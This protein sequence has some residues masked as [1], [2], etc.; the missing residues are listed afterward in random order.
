MSYDQLVTFLDSAFRS[1][2]WPQVA[3][4]GIVLSPIAMAIILGVIWWEVWV[5]YVR[6]KQFLGLKYTILDLKLPKDTFKSPLAMETVLHSIHNTSDGSMYA[7]FWKGETRP[8]YS[9]EVIS[10]EGNVK[11]LIWT[12]DRRKNNLMSALY[13]QYPGIE[14]TEMPTD[15]AADLQ[16][17]EKT[18]K[19]HC[20]EFKC[21]KPDPYPIKTYVDYGLDKDPKEEFKIDPLTHMIEWLGSLRPNE[22][23]WFQFVVRAH[24]DDQ[25]DPE[26]FFKK[27]DLWKAE[28][29]KIKNKLLLRNKETKVAGH[30]VEGSTFA[31]IPT[32]SKGEQ[33]IVAALDR[34]VTKLA[35]DVVIRALYAAP[36][37][38]FDTPYG[39]GGLISSMKQF[40]TEHL[41]GFKPN[42]DK[43]TQQFDYPWQDYKNTRRHYLVKKF[44]K[45]YRR[46]SAF[47][48]P[49]AAKP[50]VLNTEELATIYHLPGS[51][52]ATPGLARVPSK[53]AEAPVNLPT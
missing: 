36:R 42:G 29:E 32:F 9:L 6:I 49:Y 14:I 30:V 35:F 20:M 52:A 51:V 33:E 19:V 45:A 37:A 53:K 25:R 24:K 41:N 38:T 1:S 23:A 4:Y 28:A 43:W 22:Q 12:E 11:F 18:M 5:R 15:Y 7:Q 2:V 39:I 27:T 40:N 8:W 3:H 47:Y 17:D 48:P 10:I 50:V 44:L 26:H 21:T 46:R 34:S 16:Y 31:L 13:S